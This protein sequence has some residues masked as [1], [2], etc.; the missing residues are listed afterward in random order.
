MKSG[1]ALV[2][3]M[4]IAV[5]AHSQTY[6]VVK[7]NWQDAGYR[8]TIPSFP[9]T[10]NILSQGGDNTGTWFNDLALTTAIS[11]LSG[12]ARI[13][14]FPAGVYRFNSSV[15]INRDSIILRGAG[16]D[17]TTLLFNLAGAPNNLI[18]SNGSISTIDSA[19]FTAT[20]VRGSYTGTVATAA[21]FQTNDW[22]VL[23]INDQ[24]YMTSSW[25]YGSLSQT[26]QI[27]AVSG[28]TITFKSP[29]RFNYKLSDHP[30]IHK[31]NPRNNVGLECFK[32]QRAD[33]TSGQ[34]SNIV[35]DRAVNCWVKGIESDTTNFAHI[36]IN[37]SSNI[38]VT[39]SYFHDAFAYGGNGEAYGVLLQFGT[40]ECKVEGN[41]FNHLRHSMLVQAGA[42]GNVLGYN[43]STKPFWTEP[44]L[45][46]SSA[47]DIVLHGNY[48][49]MNLA[50]GNI[51]RNLV[52]DDSHGKNG[53]LNTLFRNRL[54]GY[55]IFMNFS[56]PTDSVQF[57]GNEITHPTIGLNFLS[58]V[59][60]TTYG[61]NYRGN[62]TGGTANIPDTSLYLSVGEKP[63]CEDGNMN[64]PVFGAAGRY[65]LG[66][67]YAKSRVLSGKYASCNCVPIPVIPGPTGISNIS[68]EG[69]VYIYPNPAEN[70][71]S[72]RK[73]NALVVVKSFEVLDAQGRL[74]LFN[75]QHAS[76]IIDISTLTPG[77]YIIRI[78][79]GNEIHLAKLV[80]D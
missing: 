74:V 76:P 75:R 55:G 59:G 40:N 23:N 77:L 32:I 57:I 46:D 11:A 79:S 20:A 26:M 12:N 42:N 15:N 17:S 72:F 63:G 52:I 70:S 71:I 31:I 9:Q 39:N 41:Y 1:I 51:A 47:G 13:I 49:F 44:N 45:P 7:T 65:N 67:I 60:H 54:E 28:N 37:R 68:N 33:V 29:F 14:Y 4:S 48:P 73:G 53:P 22:V 18:N 3:L 21:G 24:A 66:S 64:W 43:Y 78:N 62:I 56:P 34:T 2:F 69:G 36:E 10:I 8:G 19:L 80:K 5:I 16:Y 6:N 25:A 61:N 35:F 30:I 58:G 27:A 50:E 38:E